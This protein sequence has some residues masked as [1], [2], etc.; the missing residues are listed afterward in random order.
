MLKVNAKGG[1]MMMNFIMRLWKDEEGQGL[2]EYAL[3]AAFISIIAIV[4][5]EASGG[6]VSDIWDN[7]QNALEDGADASTPTP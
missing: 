2:I 7:I 3:I 1:E 5:L 4:A 6:F